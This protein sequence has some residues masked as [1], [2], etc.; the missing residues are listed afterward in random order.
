MK[1]SYQPA[2]TM[3]VLVRFSRVYIVL[4]SMGWAK[5]SVPAS[6]LQFALTL[7]RAQHCALLLTLRLL[8]QRIFFRV[9]FVLCRLATG[10]PA[11]SMARIQETPGFQPLTGEPQ[12]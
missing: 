2:E 3:T 6:D 11:N 8:R 5:R 10:E 12:G 9:K 1:W 4:A 7:T